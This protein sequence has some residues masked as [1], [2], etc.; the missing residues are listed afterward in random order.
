VVVPPDRKGPLTFV[1]LG[2]GLTKHVE[3]IALDAAAAHLEGQAVA[4]VTLDGRGLGGRT[5]RVWIRDGDAVVGEAVHT[6]SSDGEVAVDVPWWPVSSGTRQLVAQAHTDGSDVVPPDDHVAAAVEVIAAR[7][8]VIMIERRPSWAATFVRRALEADRRFELLGRTDV[9]PNV[10]V[11]SSPNLLDP[12]QLDRARVVVAGAPDALTSDDVS[13]LEA[14]VQRRGGAVVLVPDRAF[15]GPVARLL[16]HVWRERLDPA[17]V[18]AGPFRGTEW[19]LA[20][21]VTPPDHVWAES[22]HGPSVVSASSGAGVVLVSG[23]LDA[24]RYRSDD[25][26]FDRFWQATVAGLAGAVPGTVDLKVIRM[27][28]EAGGETQARVRGRSLRE[29]TA[30][31][32]GVR[33]TCSDGESVPV[34][35]WPDDAAGAFSGRVPLGTRTGCRLVASIAN[36]GEATVALA[37]IAGPGASHRWSRA[38]MNEIAARTGGVV[39]PD[40]TM[41]AIVQSW[42][43]AR[44]PER[45]AETRYPMR[46]WWWLLPF[47]SSLAAEWWLRRRAG[48][49]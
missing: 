39:A 25:R 44:G 2:E 20:A 22:P 13:R 48:L 27:P 10:S 14:F 28:P 11:A 19:L 32:A 4:R 36:V 24:W 7:W 15:A 6:W 33:R 16:R 31:T 1:R 9:A 35:V 41:Q 23:A 12:W 21:G 34:R 38:E 18:A 46:S 45:R 43:A 30:W 40:E 8:P 29:T 49:R 47:A 3:V 5:T 37:D 17:P 26:S 42:L